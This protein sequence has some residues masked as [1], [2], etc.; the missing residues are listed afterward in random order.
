MNDV[1]RDH[2]ANDFIHSTLENQ[3]LLLILNDDPEFL[4]FYKE[5]LEKENGMVIFESD[6]RSNAIE[7]FYRL[8]P[9]YVIINASFIA[10][11]GIHVLEGF[12]QL[13]Q[14]S[15][16]PILISLDKDDSRLLHE[17]IALADDVIAANVEPAELIARVIRNLK[18]RNRILDQILIDPMTGINNYS[19]LQQ[20]VERQLNDL[21][22]SHEPFAM[23]YVQVDDLPI[24]QETYG[25]A[26]GHQ[27]VK[28]L[29]SFMQNSIRPSDSLYR[30]HREGF[31]LVLPKTVKEDAMK[32][33]DRLIKRFAQLR[34]QSVDGDISVTFSARVLD[35][36]DPLQT[37]QQCL[38]LMPFLKDLAVDRKAS[39]MDGT[40]DSTSITLRK[41]KVGIIDD[42]RLIREMLRH[43]LEDIS[44]QD[45]EVE[46]RT[47][48]DGEEFFNDPWHRQNER[49][50]LIIDRILPKMDGLEILQKIRTQYDRRR[51]LCMMLTSRDSEEEISMAIQ[52][53]A[54]DYMVKPFSIKE[55]RARIRRLIRGTR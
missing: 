37:V 47:F 10:E 41:L 51:Y 31:V 18:K 5:H 8:Y 11:E 15:H 42:D 39:V 6:N 52:R 4:S 38:M 24:V 43:Q 12:V 7:I 19:N 17:C 54:D 35:F 16:V 25:Y 1:N 50:L 23:V 36:M 20:G 2:E 9:D 48:P 27:M 28:E 49:F 22:R 46:I 53:G 13:C 34:F 55:L 33:M 29:G 45:F 14:E 26:T 44:D 32:L 30:Y 21:K 3:P 40:A